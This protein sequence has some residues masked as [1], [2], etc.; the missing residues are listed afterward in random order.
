M[1]NYFTLIIM[2]DNI[3][4]VIIIMVIPSIIIVIITVIR[5]KVPHFAILEDAHS[6][7]SELR[8]RLRGC[9]CVRQPGVV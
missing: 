8:R 1:P 9:V 6:V 4:I 2:A 3:T 5:P 7:D